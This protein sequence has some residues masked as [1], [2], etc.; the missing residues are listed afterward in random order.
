MESLQQSLDG[1]GGRSIQGSIDLSHK[2]KNERKK[3]EGKIKSHDQKLVWLESGCQ[4]GIGIQ[5]RERRE[6]QTFGSTIGLWAI[7]FILQILVPIFLLHS[8]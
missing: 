8:G 2:K 5:G 6:K 3:S 7:L 4:R 1:V